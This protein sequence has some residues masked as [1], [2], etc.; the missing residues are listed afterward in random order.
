[1]RPARAVLALAVAA[2]LLVAC[3]QDDAPVA[4]RRDVVAALT[5]A[6]NAGDA[7]GVR[8]QADRLVELVQAQLEAGEVDAGEAERLSAL[9]AEVRTGADLIDVELQRRLEAEAQARA[10][11]EELE[12]AQ[13][14]L[15]EER[16]KAEEAAETADDDKDKDDGKGEDGEGDK[17]G[18][19]KDD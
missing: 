7:G 1:M 9:A 19:G 12:E 4:D 3:G 15:E 5:E 11:R 14:R 2:S 17:K 13:R 16:R 18:E 8:R 10:A 6:A